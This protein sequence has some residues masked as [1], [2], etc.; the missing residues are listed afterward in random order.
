L[1]PAESKWLK[2]LQKV[3]DSCPSK[4]LGAYTT[5]DAMITIYDKTV[6]DAYNDTK[7]KLDQREETAIHAN[8]GTVVTRIKTPFQIDG[9]S[10]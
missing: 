10:G 3:F 1:T 5:G 8:L 7:S 6:F 9:I 4:R 2:Q